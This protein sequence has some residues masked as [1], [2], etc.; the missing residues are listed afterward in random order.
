MEFILLY[1]MV[2]YTEKLVF[3][4]ILLLKTQYKYSE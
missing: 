3:S 4:Y 1:L 2:F